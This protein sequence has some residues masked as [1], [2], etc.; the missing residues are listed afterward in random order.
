M[1]AE[2]TDSPEEKG[3]HK[4]SDFFYNRLT[5]CGV[6]LTVLFFSV[7][8]FF[9]GIDFFSPHSNLYLGIVTYVLLPPF[10]ILGLILIPWGALRK[11][12]LVEKGIA[13]GKPKS[14]YIDPTIPSHRN[15]ILV[16]LSGTVILI[17]M[18][19][20]GSYK[21]FHYT[22]SVHFCGIVCHKVM[23]PEYTTYLNSPHAR[24]K[25]VECHIGSGADW[26]VRSKISG[27]RQIFRTMTNE[28]PRPIPAPVH[29][30]RPA[31][32]TCEQC[33][34]PGK[35][36]SAFELNRTYY[37]TQES[38]YENWKVRM[39]V[40]IG[41]TKGKD[42]GIHAHMY[43]D[44]NIYYV[45]DDEKR[46]VIPWVKSIGKDGKEKI[47]TSPDSPYK[48]SEPLPEKIRKMDC[49]DCHNRPA[50]HFL[51]PFELL[52]GSLTEG[53]INPTIPS[54]KEKGVEFLSRE[55]ASREEAVET[56]STGLRDYYQK[57]HSDF[58]AAHTQ[59]IEKAI[60]QITRMYQENFFPKM[61][62]RWD[63]HPDNI[64]HLVSAGC[65]RCHGGEHRSAE[66]EVITHDC[67]V[68]H[69]IIEQGP[70]NAL[71]KN[72]DGLNFRHP[73]D[74]D[75]SWKEMNCSDCHTG[76]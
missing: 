69:T 4:F 70:L 27:V 35:F 5:Y 17:I 15:A 58:F 73:F 21:A 39:M 65:F 60:K 59:E 36:F 16:F 19:V 57:K 2:P 28:Y 52:N 54:I 71:E 56:I 10:L 55:Y 46:Q 34:W 47:F 8:I 61:K 76:N 50:H 9:F 75:E 68:C 62:T 31:K 6:F 67:N 33:H 41:R 72:T 40:H 66:G 22:E 1:T 7:E 64:G 45:S 25:C 53:T 12:R 38:E 48:D 20:I 74:E 29:N 14:V 18:T 13:H 63:S 43:L 51:A 44:K 11:R 30:L 32:E 49:M 26:Y 3:K 24:V 37:P 42:Y 23:E